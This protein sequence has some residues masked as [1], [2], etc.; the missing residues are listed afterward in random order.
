MTDTP[1]GHN[2]CQ[3]CGALSPLYELFATCRD[4]Q[5]ETCPDCAVKGSY[6]NIDGRETVLCPDCGIA[7][8]HCD[9]KPATKFLEPDDPHD[10]TCDSCFDRIYTVCPNCGEIVSKDDL[11]E[12]GYRATHDEPGGSDT[13]CV[14]CMPEQ[15]DDDYDAECRADAMRDDL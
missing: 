15:R 11:I 4:C 10:Q 2:R 6:E 7:C 12:I 8:A 14:E 9:A 3:S 5:N 13:C 1:R